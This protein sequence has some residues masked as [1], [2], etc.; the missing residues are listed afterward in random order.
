MYQ[1]SAD[2][3]LGVPFNIASYSLLVHIIAKLTGLN[4]KKLIISFGD[5]HLYSNHIEQAK[6]QINRSPLCFPKLNI[7]KELNTIEDI[8]NCS[9]EDFELINYYCHPTIKAD[10]AV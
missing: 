9:L 7:K 10:M 1:R 5:V 6:T 4:A 3:F 2:F 8:E